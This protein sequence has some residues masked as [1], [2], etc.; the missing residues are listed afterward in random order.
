MRKTKI[1]CT[2]GPA[3]DDEQVLRKMILAGMNVA[4]LNFSHGNYQ[5]HFHRIA[6]IKRL[7]EELEVPLGILLDTKGPEIRI[8]TFKTGSAQIKTGMLFTFTTEELEGT[9]D[10]VSVT[11]MHLPQDLSIGT[12]LL[13]DDGLIAFVVE[14]LT[15]KEVICRALNDGIIGNRKSINIPGVKINLPY[16]S[17]QD[18]NDLLFGIDN[19]VD[20]IA[21]SFCRSAKDMQ[22]IKTILVE[23]N[24][25]ID[26]IAKIENL[27]GVE[28]IDEILLEVDGV[29]VARG[30]LGVEI[31]F[32]ELPTIQK[33]LINK[34]LFAGKRVITATQMLETMIHNPR[35]TRAET[36]DVA[37]AV[38]DGTSAIMLSGETSVGK[39]PVETVNTMSNI[40]KKAENAINYKER[41][42]FSSYAEQVG[43]ITKAIAHA[44]C[45][46]AHDL[47]TAAILA[48]TSSGFTSKVVSSFR[49]AVPILACT[50]NPAVIHRLSMSWGVLPISCGHLESEN[51]IFT[52]APNCAL[53]SG[54]ANDGDTLVITAGIPLGVS[55][56]TNTLRVLTIGTEL[57]EKF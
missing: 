32:E 31:E 44:T 52:L 57:S 27:E 2:L 53:S 35:P 21:A 20:F 41:F 13:I 40:A 36:S 5:E 38:Y 56:T 6:T 3:T 4:R 55:G 26:L 12:R 7:R 37:N 23:N 46:T 45:S 54:I 11:H 16:V 1:I 47:D 48:F 14:E 22:D 42:K 8:K 30:D 24:A 39:Y 50:D 51:D 10:K 43:R 9:N 34:C 18:K 19:G 49:P 28:N 15:D 25:N 33:M 17:Q 29:M